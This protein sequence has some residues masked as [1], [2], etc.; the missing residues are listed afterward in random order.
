MRN[1]KGRFRLRCIGASL[2]FFVARFVIRQTALFDPIY[3][4]A[5]PV[6]MPF[7]R[8]SRPFPRYAGTD[9]MDTRT[10]ES[11]T[12]NR[13]LAA[14][15][16]TER[17]FRDTA[18]QARS[19]VAGDRQATDNIF[20]ALRYDL[21]FG[22]DDGWPSDRDGDRRFQQTAACNALRPMESRLARGLLQT[23]DRTDSHTLPLTQEFLS[24]MVGVRRTTVTLVARQLE[25]AGVI[26]H[27]RGRIE[28]ADRMESKRWLLPQ[29]RACRAEAILAQISL[30]R[31]GNFFVLPCSLVR[32]EMS[33]T[34]HF[35]S[36]RTKFSC[37]WTLC[38][39]WK[40]Q[41][42]RCRSSSAPSKLLPISR[43]K[44]LRSFFSLPMSALSGVSTVS[45]LRMSQVSVGHVSKRHHLWADI[46]DRGSNSCGLLMP[47]GRRP[48]SW[49]MPS[50]QPNK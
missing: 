21:A 6:G 23:R 4:T 38:S 15:S 46:Q 7:R 41:D 28:I 43:S 3:T 8:A 34:A 39:C 29:I 5:I 49:L 16:S 17:A 42:W 1:G 25:Q 13:P 47:I 30:F 32:W 50:R 11:G 20:P 12:Q 35:V 2:S 40:K 48:R 14:L 31:Q 27:R 9:A 26:R 24:Q 45:R 33:G 10:A 19:S 18:D 22:R 44:H 37:D 36:P